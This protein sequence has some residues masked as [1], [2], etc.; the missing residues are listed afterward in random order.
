M[1]SLRDRVAQAGFTFG[2]GCR[3]ALLC[4]IPSIRLG[5]DRWNG[6]APQAALAFVPTN[7]GETQ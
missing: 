3:M 7:Q 1:A 2:R 5:P 4:V 6:I